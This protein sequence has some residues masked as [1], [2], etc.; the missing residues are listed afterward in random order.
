MRSGSATEDPPYFWTTKVTG[1][2]YRRQ[3]PETRRRFSQEAPVSSADVTTTAKRQRQREGRVARLEAERKAAQRAAQRRRIILGVVVVLLIVGLMAL[4]A[5]FGKDDNKKKASD[6]AAPSTTT[7]TAPPKPKITI[8]STPPPTTLQST[9][10]KPG[11]GETAQT[12]DALKVHY[13]GKI[14]ATGKEFDSTY[15]KDPIE[16]QLVSPGV[17]EGWAE[18]LVGMKAGGRRQLIIPPDLGYGP[19]GSPPE[20]PPN[21]TLVFVI[22]LLSIQKAPAATTA[23]G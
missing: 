20:I 13:V 23:P 17:I 15:E 4:A 6:R 19:Q 21:A 12:G 3:G 14:Y 11:T 8:P 18:G 7:T 2:E 16:V 5:F 1:D 10:L 22:D 9:D